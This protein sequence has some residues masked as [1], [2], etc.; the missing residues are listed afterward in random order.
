MASAM[1]G[2]KFRSAE[3]PIFSATNHG[4]NQDAYGGLDYTM[5]LCAHTHRIGVTIVLTHSTA[6]PSHS[7]HFDSRDNS[8][9]WHFAILLACFSL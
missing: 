9:S 2:F 4:D 7:F 5:L 8:S 6:T 3:R 1:H